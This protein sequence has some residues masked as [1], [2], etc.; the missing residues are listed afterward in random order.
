MGV[1]YYV[2]VPQSEVAHAVEIGESVG[3]E[4]HEIGRVEEGNRQVIFEPEQ[5]TLEPP[6]E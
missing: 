6:G 3:Y 5:I 2:I 1:G 4:I